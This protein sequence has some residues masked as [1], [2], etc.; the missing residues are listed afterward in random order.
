MSLFDLF[1]KKEADPQEVRQ[2]GNPTTMVMFRV[3]AIGYILWSLK[4]LVQAYM[5]GSE[6]APSLTLLIA[7]IVVFGAGCTFIAISTIKQYRVMKAEL[8]E[9]NEWVAAEY[10]AEEAARAEAEVYAEED[11]SD[12]EDMLE[13]PEADETEE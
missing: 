9:Y 7:T 12:D 1:K 6:E 4:D 8:A 13:L 11:P 3:I 2:P 5:A 10:A